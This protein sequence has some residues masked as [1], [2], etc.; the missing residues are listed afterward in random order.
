MRKSIALATSIVLNL[1]L[2][3]MLLF[4]LVDGTPEI[5]NGRIGVLK[6]DLDIGRFGDGKTIFTLPK[7]LIVRDASAYG[8]DRVEPHRFRLVITSEDKDLVDYTD[9]VDRDGSTA[10]KPNS[11]AYGELYSADAAKRR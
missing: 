7:G 2:A 4:A 1:A 3:A 9:G 6:R 5:A 11:A 10:S 8:L